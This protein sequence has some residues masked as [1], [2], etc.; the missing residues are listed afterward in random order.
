[1][2]LDGILASESPADGGG[3]RVTTERGE[4]LYDLSV[5]AQALRQ[6]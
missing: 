4:A 3:V 5:L 2:D 6:R 1:M